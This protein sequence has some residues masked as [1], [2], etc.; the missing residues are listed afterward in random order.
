MLYAMDAGIHEIASVAG[1]DD[2]PNL[3]IQH[4]WDIVRKSE[5]PE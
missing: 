3:C 5:Q 2:Q 4:R 1:L